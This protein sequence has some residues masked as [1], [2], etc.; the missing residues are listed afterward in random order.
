MVQCTKREGPAGG[1]VI[2]GDGVGGK[3]CF[4]RYAQV[5]NVIIIREL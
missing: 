5:D 1:K 2:V 3:G 4:L